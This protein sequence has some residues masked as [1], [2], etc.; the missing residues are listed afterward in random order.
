M[1]AKDFDNNGSYDAF[2]SLYLPASQQDLT[3]KE[4]PAQTRDDIIKQMFGMRSKFKNYKSFATATMDQLFTA[5]QLKDALIVKAT[6]LKS[7][8]FRNDGNG[9][10]TLNPL[11]AQTQFSM[12]NGMTVDDFD[13][14]GNLDLLI[15][16]NDYATDVN[17]GRYDALNGLMLKGD[18]KGN[19][20]PL[21]I[22]QS[23]IYIPGNGKAMIKLR[24]KDG[25][26]LVAAGQNRGA[27]KV[28]EL[29]RNIHTYPVQANDVSVA[30]TFKDNKTQK[31]ELYY[32]ISFLSQ[33]S[34]FLSLGDNVKSIT[35]TDSKDKTRKVDF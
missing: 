22:L 13:A 21:S 25:K 35:I 9:K 32:G 26:Y 27:L 18:G 30:I 23:G 11:P 4:F 5:E 10:F 33:S 1:Y 2:P 16:T 12:L 14:D 17:V 19:F 34:R 3:K 6:D 28:F 24:G 29:K 7:G 15:N 31:Q 20:T 8:Y